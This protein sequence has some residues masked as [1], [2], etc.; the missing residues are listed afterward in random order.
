MSGVK[1]RLLTGACFSATA[2]SVSYLY[3]KKPW[4]LQVIDGLYQI[5]GQ[6]IAAAI[7]CSW[8]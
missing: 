5:I 8:H 2:I 4:G 7:L 3:V 1:W 6:M